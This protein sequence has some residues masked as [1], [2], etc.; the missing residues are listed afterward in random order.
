MY[1]AWEKAIR[2]YTNQNYDYCIGQIKPYSW[3]VLGPAGDQFTIFQEREYKF[4]SNEAVE[5]VVKRFDMNNLGSMQ[6]FPAVWRNGGTYQVNQSEFTQFPGLISIDK[7][8]LPHSYGYHVGFASG[9]YTINFEDM[10]TLRWIGQYRITS[11]PGTSSFTDL[12]GS[13]EYE[14]RST[15]TTNTFEATTI[16]RDEWA[17]IV[18]DSGFQYA[19]NTWTPVNP[20]TDSYVSVEPADSS[21][22]R[23]TTTSHAQYP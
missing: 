9:Y 17:R 18:G 16:A 13:S 21:N 7:N 5:I 22:G 6:L 4:N 23:Y 1:G 3:T 20:V 19:S 8:D 15:P 2:A 11:A 12:A 14:R 10:D